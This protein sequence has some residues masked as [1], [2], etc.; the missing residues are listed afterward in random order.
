[1]TNNTPREST[2]TGNGARILYFDILN[3]LAILAV[4]ALHHNGIVHSYRAGQAWKE[5][6]VVECA[7]YWAVP[8]F[9][10]LSGATLM[11][12]RKRYSTVDFFRKRVLR[13][14]VPWIIWTVIMLIWKSSAGLLD[15]TGKS[16]RD[17]ISMGA[18]YQIET[19]YYFFGV[20]FACY[21]AIPV[22]SL[23]TQNRKILW[24]IAALNFLFASVRP[25]LR[26][27][28]GLQWSLDIAVVGGLAIYLLLGYLLATLE[29]PLPARTRIL[30]YLAG[31]GG[32]LLRFIYTYVR[33]IRAG[34]TDTS[35][36]GYPMFHAVFLSVAVFVLVKQIPWEKI[37]TERMQKIAA[38]LSAQSFGIFLVHKIILHYELALTG[39]KNTSFI[40]RILMVPVTYLVS[41]AVV[42]L[43]KKIP[44][45]GKVICG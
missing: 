30:I 24:Y 36:K 22:F 23:L 19:S 2:R 32:C 3:I 17:V 44:K 13:T 38:W 33:S 4:L 39:L 8:I 14:V 6:L 26:T 31:I 21:L 37:L 9:I 11:E 34:A 45:I 18:N 40:W 10:M 1:M 15:L 12:Y 16:V 35:I 25:V 20:L 29:K 43:L 5:S 41:L 28:L 27:W 42:A 7:F